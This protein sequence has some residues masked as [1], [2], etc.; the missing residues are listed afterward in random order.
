MDMM[1]SMLKD[2]GKYNEQEL[3]EAVAVVQNDP[4]KMKIVMQ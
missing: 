4:E 3:A 1:K 2:S